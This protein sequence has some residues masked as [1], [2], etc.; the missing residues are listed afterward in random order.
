MYWAPP[1]NQKLVGIRIEDWDTQMAHELQEFVPANRLDEGAA[2]PRPVL[3]GILP[4]GSWNLLVHP[5]VPFILFYS[6]NMHWASSMCQAPWLDPGAALSPG[7]CACHYCCCHRCHRS[8]GPLS[9]LLLA[10]GWTA[11]AFL[12]T[13]FCCSWNLPELSFV[14]GM[15]CLSQLPEHCP[16]PCRWGWCC[17]A[18]RREGVLLICHQGQR[19]P[20]SLIAAG[21]AF[22]S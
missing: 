4:V 13:W 22:S 12:W 19:G 16:G 15:D 10:L 1:K 5:S 9:P 6:V 14:S 2:V 8:V 21:T 20:S 3:A 11:L 7:H 17:W 18:W